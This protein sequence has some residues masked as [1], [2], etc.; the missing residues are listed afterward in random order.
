MSRSEKGQAA[1]DQLV[2]FFLIISAVSHCST[3]SHMALTDLFENANLNM[4]IPGCKAAAF[5]SSAHC[6]CT[7]NTHKIDLLVPG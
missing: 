2:V 6:Y 4:A 3:V 1:G 7:Q 5:A